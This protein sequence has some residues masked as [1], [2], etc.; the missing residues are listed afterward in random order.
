MTHLTRCLSDAT[1][2]RRG[3]LRLGVVLLIAL[4]LPGLAPGTAQA[5][6]GETQGNKAGGRIFAAVTLRTKPPGA[7]KEETVDAIIA[8]N[9]VRGCRYLLG[10][11]RCWLPVLWVRGLAF[12]GKC[13]TG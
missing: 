4:A 10:S 6:D 2:V 13:F 8:S 12:A 3:G 1:P 5:G 9:R 7:D 11:A